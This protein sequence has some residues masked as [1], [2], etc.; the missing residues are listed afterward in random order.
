[1][2]NW[3]GVGR[4]NQRDSRTTTHIRRLTV[5]NGFR[6]NCESSAVVKRHL[7][8]HCQLLQQQRDTPG[9]CSSSGQLLRCTQLL[10][11]SFLFQIYLV[12]VCWNSADWRRG[13]RHIVIYQICPK[14]ESELKEKE[15]DDTTFHHALLP[16]F[17]F[18]NLFKALPGLEKKNK[19]LTLFLPC[20]LHFFDT[21]AITQLTKTYA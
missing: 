7:A 12:Q 2:G 9:F 1:M 20:F 8:R 11:L 19:T 5:F 13:I 15:K 14:I 18:Q 6:Q 10:I 17:Q 21:H 3:M 16:R 4:W